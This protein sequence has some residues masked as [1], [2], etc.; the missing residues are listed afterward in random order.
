MPELSNVRAEILVSPWIIGPL[1]FLLWTVLLLGLKKR[2]LGAI[3]RQLD[4]RAS[5]IWADALADALAPA[6]RLAIVAGGL[7]IFYR[8]LPLSG[9]TDHAFDV[10]LAGLIILALVAFLDRISRRLFTRWASDTW[11][12]E[13]R[14]DCFRVVRVESLLRSAFWYFW[15]ASEFRLLRSWRPSESVA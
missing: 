15:I 1:V 9:R 12:Y 7:A 4:G 6:L 8:I 5:W 14:W 2:L 10:V 11:R 13:E 3:R